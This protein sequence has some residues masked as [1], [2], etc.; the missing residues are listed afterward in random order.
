MGIF[1]GFFLGIFYGFL[2]L[3][4]EKPIGIA[5]EG[6]DFGLFWVFFMVSWAYRL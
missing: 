3:N 6:R 5:Q 2:A 4:A 1:F